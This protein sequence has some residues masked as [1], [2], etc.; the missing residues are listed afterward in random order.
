MRK[1]NLDQVAL[2]ALGSN[3]PSPAGGPPETLRAALAALE[4]TAGLHLHRLSSFF[5]TPAFPADSG[6][7]YINATAAF[8]CRLTPQD[9]LARLHAV[10]A[11]LSRTRARRWGARTIDL[12]LLALG[13][14][15][16]PDKM[17]WRQW[18][19]LDL[20]QQSRLMPDQLIL[21][22][23]RLQDR[24]FVLVPLAEIAPDWC[25]PVLGRTA[26]ELLAALPAEALAGITP[27]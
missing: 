2:V 16:L 17:T 11:E 20:A 27:A 19:D 23:P 22:H 3:L 21:P 4:A 7:D 6:P 5:Q 25:H 24:G 15:V 1:L 8:T 12:D 10:E 13:S 18:H 9:L 26:A 14:M